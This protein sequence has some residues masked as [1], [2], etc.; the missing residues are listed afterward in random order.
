MGKIRDGGLLVFGRSLALLLV[1]LFVLTG[2]QMGLSLARDYSRG[3]VLGEESDFGGKENNKWRNK[4]E[5]VSPSEESPS[6]SPSEEPGQTAAESATPSPEA[7][8]PLAGTATPTPTQQATSR[9]SINAT[10][11][12]SPPR[13][14]TVPSA[15][16][17]VI[18]I[19]RQIGLPVQVTPNPAPPPEVITVKEEIVN[20]RQA[21]EILK[22]LESTVGT[23]AV[24]EVRLR[25]VAAD[26]GMGLAAE[27][28][29]GQGVLLSAA[30]VTK[31]S[32]TLRLG[33]GLK[34]ERGSGTEL[35]FSR[36]TAKAATN[37]P[38]L[39]DLDSNSL[40]VE[41]S[42]GIRNVAIL[43]DTA[44][45]KAVAL[46][47]LTD[48]EGE[49][50]NLIERDD[51]KIAYRMI[52]QAAR[53]LFGFFAIKSEQTVDVSAESGRVLPSL[54]DSL[55]ATLFNLAAP[56]SVGGQGMR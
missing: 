35:V 34:V 13:T 53:K 7:N 39:V 14:T 54:T 55:G 28:K 4:H 33:S 45:S 9:E 31:I 47:A 25:F 12:E 18:T 26:G 50:M 21:G 51:G 20:E 38:L 44:V 40:M 11:E 19:L 52:G 37:L 48:V 42:L 29:A 16:D 3:V 49:A 24:R 22:E 27:V 23:G 43:P 17:T 15:G 46:G 2:A 8:Q 1:L 5:N 56:Q 36:G 30:E 41:T 32:E 10:P 6:V